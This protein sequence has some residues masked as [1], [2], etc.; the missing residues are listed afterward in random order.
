MEFG[1]TS[2]L[3]GIFN[4]IFGSVLETENFFQV[5][6]SILLKWQYSENWPFLKVVIE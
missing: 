1:L 3:Y 2:M 6:F 5:L 4:M